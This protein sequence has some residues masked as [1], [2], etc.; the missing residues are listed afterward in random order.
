MIRIPLG[1]SAVGL[2]EATGIFYWIVC[3]RKPWRNGQPAHH[4]MSNGYLYI[5]ADNRNHSCSRL[6]WQIIK[7]E[8]PQGLEIDHIDRNK[9][10]NQITNLRIV[11][12][13]ENLL[14]RKFK[15]NTCG[16]TGVSLHNKTGL[17]RARYRDKTTY[18][19]T[20]DEAALSYKNLIAGYA[21]L[22]KGK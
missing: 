16:V 13:A 17:F 21:M 10:N 22:G 20:L 9:E 2:D 3:Y 15:P 5:K 18:H 8:I 14:N 7:G 11:T 6:V 12:R 1:K 4:I 19:K